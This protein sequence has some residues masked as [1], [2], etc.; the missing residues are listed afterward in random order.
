MVE[1]KFT[2][3][4]HLS[5]KMIS[6]EI[7]NDTVLYETVKG[8]EEDLRLLTYKILMEKFNQKYVGLNDRQKDLLREYIY[9]VSN[10]VALRTYATNMAKELVKEI[11]LKLPRLDNKIT[12]IK[13]AEV[14]VQLE[15]IKTVQIVKENHMT[16]LLIALEIT[17]TLDTLKS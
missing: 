3:V 2:I 12:K 1:A 4:E 6:K 10:S 8:Q 7:K 13:L 11:K 15:K 17:K 5:G 9:N 14:V 16:A